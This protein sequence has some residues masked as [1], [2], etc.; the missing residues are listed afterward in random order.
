MKHKFQVYSTHPVVGVAVA[1]ASRDGIVIVNT[2]PTP[3]TKYLEKV[4]E[5]FREL[6]G[7]EN[8]YSATATP[9]DEGWMYFVHD[10]IRYP[11]EDACAAV[12]AFF[13]NENGE[14]PT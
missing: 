7:D 8:T 13:N 2:M 12:Q 3:D 10:R 4:V 9:T 6:Y 5:A 14:N 1:D 11:Y